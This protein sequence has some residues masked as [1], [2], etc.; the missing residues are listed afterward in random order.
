[1]K[2]T[3]KTWKK[4]KMEQNMIQSFIQKGALLAMVKAIKINK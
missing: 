2:K 4:T 3:S 1:M